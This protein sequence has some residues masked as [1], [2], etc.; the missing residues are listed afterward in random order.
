VQW[1]VYTFNSPGPGLGGCVSA[2]NRQ[3]FEAV[4]F[5]DGTI[6][7]RYFDVTTGFGSSSGGSAT[8]GIRDAAPPAPGDGRVLQASFNTPSIAAGQTIRYSIPA[9]GGGGGAPTL[10]VVK[11]GTGTGNVKSTPPGINC[12]P[13]C[14]EPFAPDTVVRLTATPGTGS[15][16]RAWGG[17]CNGTGACQLVMS[18][19][20]NQIVSAWFDPSTSPP[21]GSDL[22]VT[23]TASADPRVGSPLTYTFTM[24]NA[25]PDAATGVKLEGTLPANVV[26]SATTA[27]ATGCTITGSDFICAI[28]D[29]ANGA[30]AEVTFSATPYR[31]GT[32][33][34]A[35]TV[36]SSGTDPNAANDSA[37][38]AAEVALVCTISGTPG[39]DSLSGTEGI[40]V[41]CAKAGDD[42]V[43]ALGGNDVVMGGPGSDSLGGGEGDDLL[44]GGR[45]DDALD[46]GP[47]TDTCEGGGGENTFLACE[48]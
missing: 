21:P 28:G 6:E 32:F 23:G 13:D 14:T 38:V 1:R 40:D 47:G 18:T 5:A 43:S 17:S 27:A 26:P 46:G 4:L 44:K 37:S 16:F 22:S 11:V 20:V 3:D 39:D 33:T 15:S 24:A 48:S 10:S 7:F 25:G 12:P 19:G 34:A 30:S 8:V 35:A 29:L 31:S 2:A 42:T 36:S 45:N 41:I 9:G